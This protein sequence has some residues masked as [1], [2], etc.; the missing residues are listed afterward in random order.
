M[1]EEA[2]GEVVT[3]HADGGLI[4]AGGEVGEGEEDGGGGGEVVE[5]FVDELAGGVVELDGGGGGDAGG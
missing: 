2:G 3:V 4:E 1:D 5:P